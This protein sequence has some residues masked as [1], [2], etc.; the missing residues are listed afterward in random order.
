MTTVVIVSMALTPFVVLALRYLTPARE[1]SLDGVEEPH[2][3]AASIL[4]IGFGRFGQVAS[5]SFLARGYDVTIID[6]DTDMIR[7][8]A[9]FGFK[10]YYGDGTRLDLLEASGARKAKLIAVCVDNRYTAS[11]IAEIVMDGFSGRQADGALL[12]SRACARTRA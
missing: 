8:A 3:L 11:K 6:N 2:D 10:V 1:P 12:R 9:N 4:M 7:S 5:Q